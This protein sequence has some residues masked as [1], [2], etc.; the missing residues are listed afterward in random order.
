MRTFSDLVQW[1]SE[2]QDNTP[3]VTRRWGVEIE[4]AYL[5]AYA[6]E[7]DEL[8]WDLH[9]DESVDSPE[10]ECECSYC[11]H[12]CDCDRCDIT[13]GYD[14]PGHCDECLS[15][16]ASSPVLFRQR[17]TLRER[18]ALKGIARR[19]RDEGEHGGHIHI[20][21]RDLT[22]AQV[23]LVQKAYLKLAEIMP[24]AF[25]R[26]YG[27]YC[28]DF[29]EWSQ[30]DRLSVRYCAVNA[31]NLIRY[32]GFGWKVWADDADRRELR[33]LSAKGEPMD[34]YKT[35]LE[36]RQFD[37]QATPELIE[38]RAALV[39]SLVDYIAEGGVWYWFARCTT[40]SEL[41]DLLRPEYH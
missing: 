21:A 27:H 15:N 18:E 1:F 8:G 6:S 28:R 14:S 22:I 3:E 38:A 20:E 4:T 10:C 2:P 19:M 35:T 7:L 23:A 5:T 33:T 31:T 24:R 17:F 36:F 25:G 11:V 30:D 37:N 40:E 13:N 12:S 16:E 39:R 41:M 34:T 29:S 26:D 9:Q 32:S